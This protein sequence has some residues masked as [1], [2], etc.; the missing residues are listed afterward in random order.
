ML[1]RMGPFLLIGALFAQPAPGIAQPGPAAAEQPE[2]G[3][4]ISMDDARRIAREHGMVRVQEIEFDSGDA[5]W[6]LEGHDETGA[7]IELKLD[8]R[9]G[10]LVEIERSRPASAAAKP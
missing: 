3:R 10:A 2:P 5:V 9:D 1:A 8:A 6:E 7:A 4:G